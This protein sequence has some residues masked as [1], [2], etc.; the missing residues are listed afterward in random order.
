VASVPKPTICVET[1]A[2]VLYVQ[3]LGSV[4]GVAATA[5]HT[6]LLGTLLTLFVDQVVSPPAAGLAAPVP[7]LPVP[8]V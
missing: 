1:P 5:P 6:T 2:T 4:P 8:I 3:P 7:V